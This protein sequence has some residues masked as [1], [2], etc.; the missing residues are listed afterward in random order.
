MMTNEIIIIGALVFILVL[1][2]LLLFVVGLV[3]Y[4]PRKNKLWCVYWYQYYSVSIPRHDLSRYFKKRPK[5][6]IDVDDNLAL[7]PTID[8]IQIKDVALDLKKQMEGLSDA[9]IARRLLC[10]VQQNVKYVSDSDQFSVS[11]QTQL[12]INTLFRLKGDC[13]D[14]AFLFSALCYHCG[15]DVKTFFI[16]GHASCGVNV[17]GGSGKKYIVDGNRYY[18]CETTGRLPIIGFYIRKLPSKYIMQAS[19]SEPTEF[20]YENC[21]KEE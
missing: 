10:F 7:C 18:W 12:P 20:W 16:T 8:D 13:E 6:G 14:T 19:P 11:D 21:L 1:A 9:Q 4:L 17:D 2:Y 3:E 5:Y 15:I